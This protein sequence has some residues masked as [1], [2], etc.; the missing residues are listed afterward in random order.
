MDSGRSVEAVAQIDR[1][2]A[3]ASGKFRIARLGET[4]TQAPI[5]MDRRSRPLPLRQSVGEK[6][7]NALR[8]NREKVGDDWNSNANAASRGRC[9]A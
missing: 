1:G 7:V 8:I 4:K 5:S 3:D 9:E 2:R 6:R